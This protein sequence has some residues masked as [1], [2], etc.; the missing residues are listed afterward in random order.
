MLA[1]FYLEN[2]VTGQC[3]K[4]IISL[5]LGLDEPRSDDMRAK[6]DVLTCRV[7]RCRIDSSSTNVGSQSICLRRVHG[8]R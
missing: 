7:Q 3:E 1:Q 5:T 6:R 2:R 4:I 8:H